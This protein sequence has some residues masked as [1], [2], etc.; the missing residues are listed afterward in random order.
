M[1]NKWTDEQNAVINLRNRNML[2]SAAAGSGKTAVLVERIIKMVT[3]ADNP[4]DIDKLCVVTFTNAAAAEMK[5]RILVA[6]NKALDE[7]ENNVHLQKQI[8]LVHTAKITTIDS[9]CLDIVRNNFETIDIDPAFK[10]ADQDEISLIKSDVLEDMLEEYYEA[11]SDDFIDFVETYSTGNKIVGLEDIIDNLYTFSISNPWP[12]I[13]LEKCRSI[14][15]IDNIEE[16]EKTDFAKKIVEQVKNVASDAEN[17][18]LTALRISREEYGP[19]PYEETIMEDLVIVRK[20]KKAQTVSELET[21]YNNLEFGKLKRVVTKNSNI[22]DEYLKERAKKLR[23]TAKKILAKPQEEFFVKS[24]SKSI[25]DI[26]KSSKAVNTLI[27]LVLDFIEKFDKK[28]REKNIVDFADIEH[29]ALDI[30]VRPGDNY[31]IDEKDIIY[32]KIADELSDNYAEILIDEYQDSNLVQDYIMNSISKERFGQPN[33]FMVGD[34]KQ[35][36]YKFRL[37]RP[38]LFMEKYDTYTI[39]ESKHQKIELRKNFRSRKNV[40]SSINYIFYKIM[41]NSVGGIEYTN[42]VALYT[43]ASYIP[44]EDEMNGKTEVLLLDTNEEVLNEYVTDISSEEDTVKENDTEEDVTKIALEARMIAKKIAELVNSSS[45]ARVLDKENNKL[46]AVKYSDIVILVR[47]QR[48]YAETLVKVLTEAGIP[49]FS[50]QKS[51]YFDAIEVATIINFIKIIDNPLQDIPLTAVMKSEI[52]G[53]TINE[54]AKMRAEQ[55]EGSMYNLVKWYI[56]N[57]SDENIQA[58]LKKMCAY[59]EDYANRS[60][61]TDIHTLLKEIITETGYYNYVSAMPAGAKRKGNLDM[62]IEKAKNYEK[63][64]YSGLFNFVRYIEKLNKYNVDYGEALQVGESANIVRLMTIHKSK[65][66]EFPIVFLCGCGKQF[67]NSD[68]RGSIVL[69]PELGIG[70]DYIDYDSRTKTKTLYKNII[71]NRLKIEA[72]GE[73]LRVLYVALTRAKEKLYIT[74]CVKDMKKSMEKWCMDACDNPD[75]LSYFTLINA[76]NYLDFIMP[77]ILTQKDIKNTINEFDIPNDLIVKYGKEEDNSDADFHIE[78]IN[79]S[80]LI[81]DS[82][83][84]EIESIALRQV[85]NDYGNEKNEL[86]NE[87][88]KRLQFEYSDIIATKIHSKMSVSEIKKIGQNVDDEESFFMFAN[89]EELITPQFLQEK[90][91]LKATTRGNAYHK[92]LEILDYNRCKNTEMIKNMALEMANNNKMP[93]E[94]VELINPFDIL[95]F[96]KS[97]IG[98]RMKKAY[99]NNTLVREQQFVMSIPY[100]DIDKEYKGDEEILIQGIIDAYFVEDGKIVLVDY[101]TDRVQAEEELI[102]RYKVQLEF[103]EKA[104][105]KT[106]DAKVSEKIIYSFA[107]KKDIR[108]D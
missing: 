60:R 55:Q 8:S 75:K 18:L 35:S 70:T 14:Y 80:D 88:D 22:Y 7:D 67:N 57:G 74:G 83:A 59:I 46:R 86:Y 47:S 78:Y 40:L 92:F 103:Y 36:I 9:F 30:L 101:K 76:K 65:G 100:K 53:L 10:I 63:T 105:N 5:E 90:E 84:G 106:Q 54:L 28:K 44:F 89:D 11:G 37:A 79:I 42:D 13:W 77:A 82:V 12:K 64:S 51:G 71:A 81:R 95:Y 17:M 3:D 23:D 26:K 49:A 33:V 50:E 104:I 91:E 15:N 16:F 72:L 25:M 41:Q 1:A 29:M 107:L 45:K 52:I 58:K 34:V 68:L 93:Q 4:V 102:S 73:E 6:L 27:D 97:D 39:N 43:G 98:Q 96:V 31:V 69:H 20:I 56:D 66:L 87:I 48:G 99:M 21:I 108:V 38:E 61:Y 2:V 85:L 24:L 19:K 94:Y 32:T 62:L